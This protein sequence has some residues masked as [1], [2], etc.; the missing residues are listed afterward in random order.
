[1]SDVAVQLSVDKAFRTRKNL[2]DPTLCRIA[3]AVVAQAIR[4]LAIKPRKSRHGT[5]DSH[6]KADA[7]LFCTVEEGEW[8]EARELWAGVAGI[9]GDAVKRE[10]L[11]ILAEH[12]MNDGACQALS[13]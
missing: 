9:D 13:E 3:K 5:A 6:A 8:L 4:D 2:A 10:A 12:N 1:M 11:G 7:R